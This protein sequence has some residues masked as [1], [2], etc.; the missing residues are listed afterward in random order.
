MS[1]GMQQRTRAGA[2]QTREGRM[3]DTGDGGQMFLG[4]M[5]TQQG[6]GFGLTGAQRWEVGRGLKSWL[7]GPV[8]ST[9]SGTNGMIGGSTRRFADPGLQLTPC[10]HS[11]SPDNYVIGCLT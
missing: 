3:E 6:L 7:A 8:C 5:E 10:P 9:A 4:T 11:L 1:A 2:S